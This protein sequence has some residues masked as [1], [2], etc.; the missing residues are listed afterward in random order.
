V[1]EIKPTEPVLPEPFAD[2]RA[3]FLE[4]AARAAAHDLSNQ[5]LAIQWCSSLL[6]ESGGEPE[7][8]R[9]VARD[10]EGAVARA[11]SSLAFLSLLVGPAPNRVEVRE[12][13]GHTSNLIRQALGSSVGVELDVDGCGQCRLE[14]DPRGFVQ[15]LTRLAAWLVANRPGAVLKIEAQTLGV[16]GTGSDRLRLAVSLRRRPRAGETPPDARS[17]QTDSCSEAG[18]ALELAQVTTY[19]EERL[20][21]RLIRQSGDGPFGCQLRVVVGAAELSEE[22]H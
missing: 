15:V 20:G 21:G 3:Q 5:L 9:E 6:D 22:N 7:A 14:A 19:L 13:I 1:I 2:D 4:W 17:G 16:A 12:L 11:Q 10:V 18:T 8:V